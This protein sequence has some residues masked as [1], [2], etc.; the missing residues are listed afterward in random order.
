M[1]P[2]ILHF[3]Q[4]IDRILHA[5]E[6]SIILIKRNVIKARGA[7]LQKLID[8]GF[9][10]NNLTG[11]NKV[12]SDALVQLDKIASERRFSIRFENELFT[13]AALRSIA[14]FIRVL[15][16]EGW[17][18]KWPMYKVDQQFTLKEALSAVYPAE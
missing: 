8:S 16:E 14:A 13:P 18:E 5:Q 1:S 3:P 2:S 12:W 9:E 10:K 17:A 15:P 7:W 6:G 4:V 11:F